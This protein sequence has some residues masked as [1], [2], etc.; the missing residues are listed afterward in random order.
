MLENAEIFLCLFVGQTDLENTDPN[1]PAFKDRSSDCKRTSG[2]PMPTTGVERHY[3]DVHNT[4]YFRGYVPPDDGHPSTT[5]PVIESKEYIFIY[6]L[7]FK[8]VDKG[9]SLQMMGY[10]SL[11]PKEKHTMRNTSKVLVIKTANGVVE[12]NTEAKV[13][14]QV[15]LASLYFKL[16]DDYPCILHLGRCLNKMGH[17]YAGKPGQKPSLRTGRNV[18]QCKPPRQINPSRGGRKNEPRIPL[19]QWEKAL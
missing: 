2:G 4:D 7:Y 17:A 6:I 18:I 3:A 12:S 8:I 13:S 11:T 14:I 10:P 15:L 19:Q 16:V 1:A 5:R 9:A